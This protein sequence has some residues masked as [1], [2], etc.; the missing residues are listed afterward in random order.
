MSLATL[1]NPT[2]IKGVVEANGTT[3][4]PVNNDAYN[5]FTSV[6][7]FSL[8]TQAGTAATIAPFISTAAA[9]TFSIKSSANDTSVY[10]YL[11]LNF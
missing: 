11:I 9:G 2:Q 6:V 3:A 4:V 8:N 10:N 5:P 7:V 1:G